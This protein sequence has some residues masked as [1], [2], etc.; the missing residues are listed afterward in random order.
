MQQ[1]ISVDVISSPYQLQ[2]F[3]SA[4]ELAPSTIEAWGPELGTRAF[5]NEPATVVSPAPAQPVQHVLV[6]LNELGVDDACTG[7][8]P[9]RGRLG[10]IAPV[11]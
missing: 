4:D 8:N 1:P 2:F 9:Y 11:G 6:L 10:E 7:V 5:A 3:A